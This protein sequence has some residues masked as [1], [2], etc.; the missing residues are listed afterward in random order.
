MVFPSGDH[1]GVNPPMPIRNTRSLLPSASIM[2]K[3]WADSSTIVFPSGEYEGAASFQLLSGQAGFPFAGNDDAVHADVG[4][5]V[6]DRG[7]A[8][9]AVGG[10]GAGEPTT[11]APRG[12]IVHA[13]LGQLG[14]CDPCL[15]QRPP[16]ID[17]QTVRIPHG[18]LGQIGQFPG[19]PLHTVF[20]LVATQLAAGP[21]LRGDPVCPLPARERSRSLV[22]TA[23]PA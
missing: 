11:P 4:E 2:E 7:F 17:Q 6:V 22:R 5:G 3:P 18:R 10:H 16:R 15:P 9:P 8:V 20:D 1:R 14:R 12:R 21:Q 23:P 19:D 13:C